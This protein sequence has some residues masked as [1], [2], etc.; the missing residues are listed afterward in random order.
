IDGVKV[1]VPALTFSPDGVALDAAGIYAEGVGA[2]LVV[3]RI[4]LNGYTVVVEDGVAAR[5]ACAHALRMR[6]EAEKDGGEI[7][8]VIAEVNLSGLRG[9]NII[10]RQATNEV[11][12]AQHLLGDRRGGLH[13]SK[14]LHRRSP[15]ETGDLDAREV[16]LIRR[17]GLRSCSSGLRAGMDR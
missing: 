15:A 7:R 16:S 1:R 4:E 9:R 11:G 13:L 12:D 14:V 17:R 5:T 6:V 10:D 2:L 3:K 8:A